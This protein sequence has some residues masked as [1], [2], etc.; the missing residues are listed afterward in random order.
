VN[1]RLGDIDLE[2]PTES[3]AHIVTVCF[4]FLIAVR[5]CSSITRAFSRI[6]CSHFDW[7]VKIGRIC[8]ANRGLGRGFIDDGGSATIRVG[9]GEDMVG[10]KRASLGCTAA[11]YMGGCSSRMENG[12]SME[13]R[14]VGIDAG[15]GGKGGVRRRGEKVVVAMGRVWL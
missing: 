9:K 10:I 1:N 2:E 12:S 6:S 4:T 7:S 8:E 13:E 14:A 5:R 3:Q 15:T 11:G